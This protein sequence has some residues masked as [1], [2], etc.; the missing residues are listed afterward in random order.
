MSTSWDECQ[1]IL[2]H[3]ASFNA[4]GRQSLKMLQIIHSK[5]L[6]KSGSMSFSR[7]FKVQRC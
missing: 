7:P 4:S 6:V 3:V 1:Q 2:K 5:V